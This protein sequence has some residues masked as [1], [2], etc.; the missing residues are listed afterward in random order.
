MRTL[1][2]LLLAVF[3]MLAFV[4]P[5]NGCSFS[6][7]DEDTAVHH[8][9]DSPYA[10][11]VAGKLGIVSGDL[12]IRHLVIAY[13]T[14]SG[15][16][17][18][19]AEQ[20]A[21][22]DVD[23]FYNFGQYDERTPGVPAPQNAANHDAADWFAPFT[24]AATTTA[25]QA[26]RSVP[27][28]E[29]QTFSNCLDDAF[30]HAASTL[31]DRRSRYTPAAAGG[32]AEVLATDTPE[33][34]DWIT[35]QRAVFSN[36]S[37]KGEMPQPAPVNA[38]LWLKQDRAYQT[39]AA[40]FYATD[41]DAA[42]AGFRAIAA[43]KA[44]P[45]A[46]LARYVAARTLIRKATVSSPVSGANREEMEA[47]NGR[48]RSRLADARDQLQAILRDPTMS[49]YHAP[50][51]HLLDYV[52]VRLDPAAQTEEL[53][54]RL[55]GPAKDKPGLDA[56]YRQNVIDLTFAYNSLPRYSTPKQGSVQ[57][58]APLLRW[59]NDLSGPGTSGDN[60]TLSLNPHNFASDQ[61]DALAAW[62]TTHQPQWLA[63]ALAAAS[64]GNSDIPEMT[65]AARA[66][67]ATSPAYATVTYHRLRLESAAARNQPASAQYTELAAL[68]PEIERTQPRTT[69][70]LFADLQSS[71]IPSLDLF[72]STATR[73]TSV[74][75]QD[76]PGEGYS[77]IASDYRNNPRPVATVCGVDTNAPDARHL[78]IE[79]ALIFNQ[80][81]PLHMLRD[82]ALSPSL[83]GN[84]RF[85][86]AHMAWTRAI[87]LD[88]PETAHALAPSLAQCQPAF[89]TWLDQYDAAKTPD[90]RHV[91]GLLAMMRFASTSPEVQAAGERDFASYS[92]REG[93]WWCDDGSAPQTL[94]AGPKPV[95]FF[96]HHIVLHNLA[97]NG[98]PD[99]PFLTAADR[100]A[101]DREIAALEKVGTASDYFARESLAWVKAHPTDPRNADVLGFAMRVVRN[102]CRT[103]ATA[104]LNHQLFDTLHRRYPKSEWAVKYTTW[105]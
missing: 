37:G 74:S 38:P 57:P 89:K 21:A 102:A 62:R 52:M 65:A 64:P 67:P 13:N 85:Q 66:L 95:V 20:K 58:R 15:R 75:I 31:V 22:I 50:A 94:Y 93:N 76:E 11:F 88:D 54:R 90:D 99:P 39:A 5:G 81:M 56:D 92:G 32:A 44:S 41:Y 42:L 4:H 101:A 2:H 40:S 60:T 87:L 7:D 70:N 26:E 8:D 79:T 78:D 53:A 82:A 49:Q 77:S 9:P 24:S 71:L 17:L 23:R 25:R 46:Q 104:E 14:L 16:G 84:V 96:S 97:P 51:Q 28:S 33:I 47:N 45:W 1:R 63:A 103:D 68:M 72:L 105:E 36:C 100:T 61:Q 27:G 35:G 43:D 10:S 69:I 83:P 29:Y 55:T 48:I 6:D 30:A 91:L 19:P 59:I 73:V 12:R 18:T 3:V 80:R 98:E 86:L 34:R